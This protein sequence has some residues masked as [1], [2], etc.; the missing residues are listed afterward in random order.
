MAATPS[1]RPPGDGGPEEGTPEWEWLYGSGGPGGEESGE[2]GSSGGRHRSADA[3]R[4]VPQ[5][6][7]PEET[8]IMPVQPPSQT[9]RALSPKDRRAQLREQQ[10]KAMEERRTKPTPPPVSPPPG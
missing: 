7:R 10:A 1:G 4:P 9:Q 2:S 3:T 8:R 6:E 5:E